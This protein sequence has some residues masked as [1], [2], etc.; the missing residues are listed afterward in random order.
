MDKGA[1]KLIAMDLDGTL[2]QHKTPLEEPNRR[3]LD[4]L[5][6][7]HRLLMVGAGRCERIFR[8]MGSYPVDILGNYGLQY[9]RYDA[10]DRSLKTVFDLTIP[11]DREKVTQTIAALRKALG[12]GRYIG[13]S[14]EFHDSGLHYVSL[15]GHRRAA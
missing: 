7:N 3:A 8:Q 10:A 11:C 4:I 6:R 9:C 2:T 15:A 5:G 12:C 1:V 14:V 13:D